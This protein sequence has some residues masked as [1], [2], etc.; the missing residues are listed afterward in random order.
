MGLLVLVVVVGVY[1][2]RRTYSAERRLAA[3]EKL[4]YH[5]SYNGNGLHAANGYANGSVTSCNGNSNGLL[6]HRDTDT[7]MEMD[8]PTPTLTPSESSVSCGRSEAGTLS[9]G[10]ASH[11]LESALARRD[12][13]CSRSRRK[14]SWNH[15][16]GGLARPHARPECSEHSHS[17]GTITP[18]IVTPS[19]SSNSAVTPSKSSNSKQ[20]YDVVF[21]CVR[22]RV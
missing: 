3:L 4:L 9:S 11:E 18:T 2:Y 10:G 8:S 15:L 5:Y 13:K 14:W 21:V 20:R 16:L 7:E 17:N 6:S 1:L 19:K 12:S 22:V